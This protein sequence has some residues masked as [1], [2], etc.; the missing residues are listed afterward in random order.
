MKTKTLYGD[1]VGNVIFFLILYVS[2]ALALPFVGIDTQLIN[3]ILIV[4]V[5][6]LG[7][8]M[9][10]AIGLGLKDVV[11]DIGKTYSKR[12]MKKRRK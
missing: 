6:S 9:A 8:G 12:F 1:I 11:R 5:A 2:V 4:V 7:L 10:I 3:W